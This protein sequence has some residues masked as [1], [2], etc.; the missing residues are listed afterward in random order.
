MYNRYH[1]KI[2]SLFISIILYTFIYSILNPINFSGINTIQDK[3]KDKLGEE[4]IYEAFE[5]Q[6]T[7][8]YDIDK[9]IIKQDVKKFIAEEDEKIKKPHYSQR[10]IDSFLF[11]YYNRVFIRLW[12]HTPYNKYV[13]NVSI[14]TRVIYN[15]VN[16][17]LVLTYNRNIR[18]ISN[19]H[20]H[21]DYINNVHNRILFYE[22]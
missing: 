13:K 11:F 16:F 5:G 19:V 15:C 1:Y 18:K 9:E 2:I 14:Y 22:L 17:V 3:I 10:I 20:I 12:R 4:Q 8:K 6:Y 7:K 21:N